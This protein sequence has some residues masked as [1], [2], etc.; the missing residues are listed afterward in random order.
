MK[1]SKLL[2]KSN[3]KSTNHLKSSS[4]EQSYGMLYSLCFETRVA[5]SL[6]CGVIQNTSLEGAF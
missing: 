3:I 2:S 6:S 1:Q 5:F 4:L